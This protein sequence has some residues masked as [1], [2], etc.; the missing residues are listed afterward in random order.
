MK[1]IDKIIQIVKGDSR[2]T[3]HGI[4]ESGKLYALI[5]KKD[6]ERDWKRICDSPKMEVKKPRVSKEKAKIFR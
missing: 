5:I 6:G 1:K 3:I 2:Y 4:S